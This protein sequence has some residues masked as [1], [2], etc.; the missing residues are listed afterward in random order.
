MADLSDVARVLFAI[1][2]GTGLLAALRFIAD[3]RERRK[4]RAAR[5]HLPYI[6]E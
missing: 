6:T 2:C 1:G 3:R 4:W 5:R